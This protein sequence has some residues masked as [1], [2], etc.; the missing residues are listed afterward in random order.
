MISRFTI[1]RSRVRVTFSLPQT[2]NSSGF[3]VR[4]VRDVVKVIMQVGVLWRG[5]GAS[6]EEAGHTAISR[7]CVY[8][9][10]VPFVPATQN[11]KRRQV[12]AA[13]FSLFPFFL[14]F[15]CLRTGLRCRYCTRDSRA[16]SS[17]SF[18][19]VLLCSSF[20]EKKFSRVGSGFWM[21]EAERHTGTEYT[22]ERK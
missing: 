21:G 16:I 4:T 19:L 6:I 1:A 10:H 17:G 9:E 7:T 18:Q 5:D 8:D 12:V 13:S 15:F 14:V 3:G 2:Q 22:G 11:I 20:V